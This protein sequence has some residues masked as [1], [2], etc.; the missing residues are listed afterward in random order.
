MRP[1]DITLGRFLLCNVKQKKEKLMK[2]YKEITS[3]Y[4]FEP[5]SG[6]VDTYNKLIEAGKAEEFVNRLEELFCGSD[7]SETDIND[8]LWFEPETCYELVGLLCNDGNEK[9]DEDEE[10]EEDEE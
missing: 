7:L 4:D 6:A 3:L 2:V 1:L 5:W 10:E 9:N 8:M